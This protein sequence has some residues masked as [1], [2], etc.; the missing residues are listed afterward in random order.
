MG[1]GIEMF[2]SEAMSLMQV[3]LVSFFS[4]SESE[5]R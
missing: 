3:R 5:G 4:F 2:R 1:G